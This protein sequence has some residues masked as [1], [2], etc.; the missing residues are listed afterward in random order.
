MHVRARKADRGT[1][2]EL[3]SGVEPPASIGIARALVHTAVAVGLFIA[4]VS[5]AI[6][7][8]TDF[9]AATPFLALLAAVPYLVYA[10]LALRRPGAGAVVGGVLLLVIG[11]WGYVTSIDSSART[12]VLLPVYLTGMELSVFALTGLLR[13]GTTRRE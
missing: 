3:G 10:R 13:A 2:P 11:S 7:G 4:V 8:G 1:S 9:D 5:V 12:L 6:A